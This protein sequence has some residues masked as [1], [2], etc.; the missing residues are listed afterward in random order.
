MRT[1]KDEI[2][3]IKANKHEKVLNEQKK[4]LT[5]NQ[6]IERTE[7]HI[8]KLQNEATDLT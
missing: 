7:D 3:T 4:L 5:V 2:A 6:E 8:G 1:W